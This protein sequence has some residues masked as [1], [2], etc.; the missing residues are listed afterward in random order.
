MCCWISTSELHVYSCISQLFLICSQASSDLF[1]WYTVALNYIIYA[2][3]LLKLSLL[4]LK[5]VA[6]IKP[7]GVTLQR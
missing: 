4:P 2:D 6:K 7:K 1:V 5:T 3:F